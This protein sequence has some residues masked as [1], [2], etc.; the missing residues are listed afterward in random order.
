M[1]EI[2]K[3]AEELTSFEFED[4]QTRVIEVS[5]WTRLRRSKSAM[6]GL[7]LIV[8]LIFLAITAN[9]ISPYQF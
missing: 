6:I 5:T 1:A 7:I 4:E 9:L 8:T 3:V 2:K